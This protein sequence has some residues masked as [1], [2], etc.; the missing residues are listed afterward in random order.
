MLRCVT[1]WIQLW[2]CL[3]DNNRIQ[4]RYTL[5]YLRT[6]HSL[7][8]FISFSVTACKLDIICTRT[9]HMYVHVRTYMEFQYSIEFEVRIFYLKF[10]VFMSVIIYFPRD[11]SVYL[12]YYLFTRSMDS[13]IITARIIYLPPPPAQLV[14][15]RHHTLPVIDW[16]ITSTRGN[17][18]VTY[19]AKR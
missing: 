8:S 12:R 1:I 16:L 17:Q 9:F 14:G 10:S 2:T 5:I 11:V 13:Y 18:M 15:L 3:F 19:V 7:F 6:Y 4:S